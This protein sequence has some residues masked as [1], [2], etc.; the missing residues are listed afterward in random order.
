[1]FEEAFFTLIG[2]SFETRQ[3]AGIMDF[4]GR[5]TARVA[6]FNFKESSKKTYTKKQLK[7]RFKMSFE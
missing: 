4:S 6:C 7:L 3:H 1:M 2:L 5:S